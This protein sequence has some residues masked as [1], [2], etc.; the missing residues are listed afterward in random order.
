MATTAKYGCTG[1]KNW[2]A[3]VYPSANNTSLLHTGQPTA[4]NVMTAP[5]IPKRDPLSRLVDA[6][7]RAT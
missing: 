2:I 6:S 4:K 7:F 3:P 5:V 1:S